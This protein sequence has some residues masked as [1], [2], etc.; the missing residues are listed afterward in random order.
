MLFT[1]RLN[2]YQTIVVHIILTFTTV[3]N[4]AITFRIITSFL[5]LSNSVNL[6][7]QIVFR[8]APITQEYL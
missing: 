1:N 3:W 8:H 4:L 5:L 2:L 7:L 6:H